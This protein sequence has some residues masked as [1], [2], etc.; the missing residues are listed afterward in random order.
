KLFFNAVT[1]VGEEPWVSDGTPAGTQLVKD[2]NQNTPQN[3]PS[4]NPTE[5]TDVT[6]IAYF[7]ATT[8]ADG[9]ELWRSD[10]TAAGTWEVADLALGDSSSSPADLISVGGHLVFDT[11]L[12]TNTFELWQYD[13]AT[14]QLV[15]Y[16]DDALAWGFVTEYPF[17][18]YNDVL[19]F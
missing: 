14:N 15:S 2:I 1:D 11:Q 10:G 19:Y 18:V 17:A 9:R 5:Y 13:P 6:G 12:T 3:N 4:S 16:P 7:A 8:I